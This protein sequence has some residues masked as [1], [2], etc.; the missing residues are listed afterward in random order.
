MT[1]Q[2]PKARRLEGKRVLITQA[3]EFMG[4]ATSE[5]FAAHGA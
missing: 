4:A 3:D 1:N 5:L 2:E